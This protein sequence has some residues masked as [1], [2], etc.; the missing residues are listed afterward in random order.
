MTS[1]YF[2]GLFAACIVL[3]AAAMSCCPA[4]CNEETSMPQI[5]GELLWRFILAGDA[6][7]ESFSRL[8]QEVSNT[9]IV[10]SETGVAGP[11]VSEA[12]LNLT[13][14][15]Q[16][17]I[18]AVTI[19]SNITIQEV[20]PNSFGYIKGT[21]IGHQRQF[22]RLFNKYSSPGFE[23]IKTIEGF[24][25]MSCAYPVFDKSG[26]ILG[27]VD[28]LINSTDFLSGVLDPLQPGGDAKLW[29]MEAEDGRILYETDISQ[30][31]MTLEDPIFQQFPEILE[32]GRQAS[33][34]RS[35]YGTYQFYD[36]DG[37][38]VKK[39]LYWITPAV[40][41]SNLRLMLTFEFR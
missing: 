7:A 5:D 16:S 33:V 22:Q 12:L 39:A 15:D 29:V 31:G 25:A 4:A 41:G 36:Q 21:E 9:A 2:K 8:D 28:L 20:E 18:D 38:L 10:L 14:A 26:R 3:V 23:T 40:P 17:V 13:K 30:I 32:I 11:G 35:G 6:L 27:A 19:D 1:T 24:Y 34:K 37:L